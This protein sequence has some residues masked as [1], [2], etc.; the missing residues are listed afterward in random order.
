MYSLFRDLT[1]PDKPA[2]KTY[3]EVVRLL[4][5]HL[6]TK[7]ISTP[8]RFRF[9]KRDQKKEESFSEYIA[10]LKNVSIHCDFK[11]SLNEK[12]RDRIVCGVRNTRFRSDCSQKKT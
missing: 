2:T 12:L 5:I 1:F 9:D 3:A 10:Q 6:S 4:S 7:K 11:A 8:E